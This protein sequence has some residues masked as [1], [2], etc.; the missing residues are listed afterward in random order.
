MSVQ[1][2]RRANKKLGLLL[3]TQLAERLSKQP[4]QSYSYLLR[5]SSPPNINQFLTSDDRKRFTDR[6]FTVASG[7]L[8]G[9][10]WKKKYGA[11]VIQTVCKAIGCDPPFITEPAQLASLPTLLPHSA[12]PSPISTLFS[13]TVW[14]DLSA[15]SQ[16]TPELLLPA[17]S[18]LRD[19][20]NT[21]M[22]ARGI[23]AVNKSK[24]KRGDGDNGEEST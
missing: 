10:P 7:D 2:L 5:L 12:S 11:D 9:W 3:H 15:S 4:V 17:S 21:R 8:M 1:R 24:R 20:S 22:T 16:S 6:Y 14:T 23:P 18:I 19:I 13:S